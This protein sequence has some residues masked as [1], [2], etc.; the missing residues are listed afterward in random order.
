MGATVVIIDDDERFRSLVR[1]LLSRRGF[2]VVAETADGASGAAAIDRHN[3]NCALVDVHLPDTDGYE[4]AARLRRRHPKLAILV[5]SIDA[6]LAD[7]PTVPGVRFVT[8][9][10]IADADLG[11]L[12]TAG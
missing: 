2:S 10:R 3:P 6:D 8:K 4:L 12:F 9:D 11:A 1:N 7:V 5:T